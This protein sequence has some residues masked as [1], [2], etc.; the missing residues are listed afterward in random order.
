MGKEFA[1]GHTLRGQLGHYTLTRRLEECV[2]TAINNHKQNV[3]IKSVRHWRLQNERDI[4]R[5]LQHQTPFL[6]PIIDEIVEPNDPPGIVLRWL[7][8]DVWAASNKQQLTRR[9]VKFVAKGVLESLKTLHEN[10]YVHTDIKPKNVL[11]NYGTGNNRIKEV[12]L[13]DLGGSLPLDS[14]FLKEGEEMGTEVFRSPEAQLQLGLGP[15]MDIWAF[16]ATVIGLLYGDNFH[17]FAPTVPRSDPQYHLHLLIEHHRIFGPWPD[18]YED[19][20]DEERLN[21]LAYTMDISPSETLRPFS[22]TST[23][24]LDEKDR[25][26][27]CRIMKLD[28]RD[29]PTAEQLLNDE[30]LE[31]VVPQYEAVEMLDSSWQVHVPIAIPA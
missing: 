12:Q 10:G 1:I 11:I 28:P 8:E 24:E 14:K 20:C 23:A 17:I 7:D 2:W 5:H 26:F 15:P 19:I 31:D 29:R 3:I 27:I 22:H 18:S 6:R 21:V 13:A 25:D 4:L 9:E 16:G 30:W